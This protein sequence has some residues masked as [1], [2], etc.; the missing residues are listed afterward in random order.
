[1]VKVPPID[2]AQLVSKV[3]NK[4]P[5]D[6]GAVLFIAGIDV[7]RGHP[8]SGSAIVIESNLEGSWAL[9]AGHVCY[10]E[11]DP[12]ALNIE[13]WAMLA[14]DVYGDVRPMNIVAL[15][16]SN[17]VCVFRVPVGP[18]ASVPLAE[19]QINLG[20]RA[21]LGAYPGGMYEPGFVPLFEGFY[22]GELTVED[23][24]WSG[25]TIPVAPGSS[26]GGVVNEKGE[27]IGIVSMAINQFENITLAA[28]LEN[29]QNLLDVAKKNP[30]RL[31]IL[32]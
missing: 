30:D 4:I 7:M 3:Q 17:D 10:P 25:F 19:K 32:H 8:M 15:D 18:M 26:G 22:S 21:F 13:D 23:K 12:H 11:P 5:I 27:L 14:F 20:D 31:T 6:P 1:M 28:K 9:S 24:K 29:I 2:N 16:M